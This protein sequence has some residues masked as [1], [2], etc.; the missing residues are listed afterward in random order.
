MVT[1]LLG[2]A[3]YVQN[4]RNTTNMTFTTLYIDTIICYTRTCKI[5]YPVFFWKTFCT[6][7]KK[8]RLLMRP[9]II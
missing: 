7:R 9:I 6:I 8:K 5:N 3:S 1:L 4:L 2:Q